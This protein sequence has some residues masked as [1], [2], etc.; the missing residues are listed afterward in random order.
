MDRKHIP[1]RTCAGCGVKSGNR[2]LIRIVFMPENG[3]VVDSTGRK[4]GRGTYLC[5]RLSCWE[6]GVRKGRIAHTLGHTV[7]S[8][9]NAALLAYAYEHYEFPATAQEQDG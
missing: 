4:P 8:S 2:D 1:V 9:E 6:T 3:V 5:P 7:S